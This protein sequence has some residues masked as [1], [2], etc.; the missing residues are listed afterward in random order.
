MKTDTYTK[1]VLTIIAICLICLVFKNQDIVPTANA[2]SSKAASML[3]S[4]TVDVRIV[5]V[6]SYTSIPV[7]LESGNST[8]N[9]KITGVDTYN[10]L[11]VKI[12]STDKNI[13]VKINDIA[14]YNLNPLPVKIKN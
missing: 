10:A 7:K 12:E 4:E 5:G 2:N 3:S 14:I 11:P 9:V 13:P 1:T 6:S 8:M